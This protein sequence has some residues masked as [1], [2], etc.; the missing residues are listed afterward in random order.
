MAGCDDRLRDRDVLVHGNR[1]R[2]LH[3]RIG[4][5]RSP[6]VRPSLPPAL[7]PRANAPRG[8]FVGE[9]LQVRPR[10]AAAS[11]RASGSRGTCRSRRWGIRHARLKE[12]QAL[13]TLRWGPTPSDLPALAYSLGPL[14]DGSRLV[15][16]GPR[17][18][19]QPAAGASSTR[20]YIFRSTQTLLICV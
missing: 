10:P 1:S 6:V 11:H 3:P 2:V 19:Q 5:S 13:F 17:C 14:I 12:D 9:L 18:S 20:T 15:T 8:P 7:V 4:A 16:F